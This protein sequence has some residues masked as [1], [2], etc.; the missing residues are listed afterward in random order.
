MLV[1]WSYQMKPML[2]REYSNER[3]VI[4]C[5]ATVLIAVIVA[6]QIEA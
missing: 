6:S 2:E 1:V 3:S 4:M 5:V